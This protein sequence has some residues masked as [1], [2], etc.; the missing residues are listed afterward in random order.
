MSTAY[1]P[2]RAGQ[3]PLTDDEFAQFQ[4]LMR[5]LAGITLSSSKKALVCSRLGR[6]LEHLG[7]GSYADYLLL[8]KSVQHR[9][10][11]QAAVDLLT[12][13]ETSFFREPRHFDFLRDTILK[14]RTER[15]PFRVWSAACSSGEEPYTLSM[16]LA[17]ALGTAPWEIVASDLSTRM[18]EQARQARY[19]MEDARTIAQAYLHRYCLK[20][21]GSREGTFMIE[22]QLRAR[23]DF[24]Q[25]NLHNA[26]PAM[27][28]FDVIFLRNVMIYFDTTVKRQVL[29]RLV[30]ALKPGG[31]L[32][33]GHA[34][35]LHGI[36]DTVQ[37]V[38]P[39]IYRKR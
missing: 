32:M 33:I 4:S 21:V 36:C 7:L 35:S 19:P 12:T 28:L 25:I 26:L 30:P 24:R 20:G 1:A 3:V 18:L 5:N 10:E 11:L 9:Q 37:T 13:N 31:Y 23:V 6:R 16:V 34:E 17:D 15:A 38:A 14:P 29:A 39:A 22:S 27:G 2:P 8:L